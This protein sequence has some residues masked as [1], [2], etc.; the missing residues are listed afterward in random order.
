MTVLVRIRRWSLVAFASGL[1]LQ[2]CGVGYLASG[3]TF[4]RVVAWCSALTL[5]A[6]AIGLLF[7]AVVWAICSHRTWAESRIP[8]GHCRKCGYN[9]FENTSGR[10]PECGTPIEQD[11]REE[12]TDSL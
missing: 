6:G 4:W 5:C 9:V 2:V 7:S 8:P 1:L 10:C 3:G 11:H 12:A